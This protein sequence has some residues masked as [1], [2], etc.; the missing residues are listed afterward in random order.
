MTSNSSPA[1]LA[2]LR[3]AASR[4]S[5]NVPKTMST[6]GATFDPRA[7]GFFWL[8]GQGGYGLQT[9]PAMAEAVEALVTGGAWH[10]SGLTPEQIAPARLLAG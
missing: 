4:S 2:K 1:S 9:A 7:P 3:R 10:L 5:V 8:C 6:G